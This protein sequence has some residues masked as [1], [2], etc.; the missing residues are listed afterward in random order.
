V[1]RLDGLIAW[2]LRIPIVGRV[3]AVLHAY[4]QAGGGLLAAGLAFSS[5]FALLP[6]ILL[7][8]GLAGLLLSDPVRLASLTSNL[9][10]RFPPLAIFF[11]Q[12]LTGMAN[13]ALANSIVG[14]VALVWGASRLYDAL[15]RAITRI[16]EG[17]IRRNPV[18]RGIRGV[19]AVLIAVALG[20]AGFLSVSLLSGLAA[21]SPTGEGPLASLLTSL[22][23]S[24][25]LNILF[26]CTIAGLIYRYVP[27]RQPTWRSIRGPAIV[28]GV[29]GAALT[30]FFA[31][32]APR[33][34][35]SLQVYG[36]LVALLASMI[37]LS[38]I[39]QGLLLGAAWV[40]ART[41]E[42][43]GLTQEPLA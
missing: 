4:E 12:A 28:V 14:F 35:G 20:V 10:E 25:L 19:L 17:S 13:G 34:V 33:L 27:T 38:F 29:A 9:S 22:A 6:A 21:S 36:A 5:L 32:L 1:N 24:V 40:Q 31:V 15:D 42:A 43:G 41:V 23:G 8:L 30:Q 39:S 26:F 37:W 3:M 18:Q 16:F 2:V 11:D 7:L